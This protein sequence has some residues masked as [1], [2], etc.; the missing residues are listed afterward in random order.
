MD[1][2]D[3]YNQL[4][5]RDALAKLAPGVIVVAALLVC[6]A[7]DFKA[8]FAYIKENVLGRVGA[9]IGCGIPCWPRSSR[10]NF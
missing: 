9:F 1:L 7:H 4:F 6:L 8:I 5:M 3:V 2:G 10:N